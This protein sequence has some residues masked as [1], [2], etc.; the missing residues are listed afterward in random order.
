MSAEGDQR[1]KKK[2]KR[3]SLDADSSIAANE[4]EFPEDPEGGLYGERV[5]GSAAAPLDDK[6]SKKDQTTDSEI[7]NHEF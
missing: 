2:K 3:R 1:K 6:S 4:N 5:R 7:F